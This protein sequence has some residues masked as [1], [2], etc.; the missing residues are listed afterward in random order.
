METK[1][2]AAVV[3]TFNRLDLLQM[4]V[5][6]L[7]KQT[8]P[9]LSIIIINNNSSDGT[10]EFL[11][12]WKN[13][14]H[15]DMATA[16]VIH[17]STNTGGAGG[18]NLGMKIAIESGHDWVWMMDDDVVAEDDALQWLVDAAQNT[19][20]DAGFYSSMALDVLKKYTVN[21]PQ[22]DMNLAPTSYPNWGIHLAAGLVKLEI[23][24]F[25]SILIPR[26][27]AIEAGLPIREFFIWGDD[28]E[29]T[30]RLNRQGFTGYWV[31]RSRVLHLRPGS[32]GLDIRK[33]NDLHRISMY[34]NLYRNTLFLKRKYKLEPMKF[35]RTSLTRAAGCLIKYGSFKKSVIII[36][37]IF[38]GWIFNP[39]IEFPSANRKPSSLK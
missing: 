6:A 29:Y 30:L 4:C 19:S 27:A 9:L 38:A 2:I 14:R 35:T 32:Q 25:V 18:F 3:V 12:K 5:E 10:K 15:S 8:H 33:E 11:E 21:V 17:L 20:G 23:S 24:T 1:K 26:R 36:R 13:G 39:K 34:I 37:G 28:T 31:G 16:I 7:D 22:I